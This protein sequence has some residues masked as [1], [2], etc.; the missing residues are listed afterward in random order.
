MVYSVKNY[1]E[2]EFYFTGNY[3]YTHNLSFPFVTNI[4]WI[5]HYIL[6]IVPI[7]E[8]FPYYSCHYTITSH[9]F[10]KVTCIR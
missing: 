9:D 6:N 10:Y 1:V 8:N 5:L 2:K 4:K 3:K 7:L